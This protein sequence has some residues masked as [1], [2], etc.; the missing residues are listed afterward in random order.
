[1][2]EEKLRD[3]LRKIEALHAGASTPGEERAA[4]AARERIL[5]RLSEF[6]EADPV[7]ECR[8][9]LRDRFSRALFVALLRRYGIQPYR[10]PRQRRTTVMAR[11]SSSFVDEI[12]WPEFTELDSTLGEYLEEVTE[13]VIADSV[14]P[15]VSEAHEMAEPGLVPGGRH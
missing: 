12:L 5:A 7:F 6:E 14:H 10:Y 8:F 1:M 4:A 13:R 9:R 2:N 3:K 15:D 11:A